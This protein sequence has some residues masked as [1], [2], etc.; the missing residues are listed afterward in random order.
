MNLANLDSFPDN[1]LNFP[2]TQHIGLQRS[3]ELTKDSKK[4]KLLKS[5]NMPS[6]PKTGPF[7]VKYYVSYEGIYHNI[8]RYFKLTLSLALQFM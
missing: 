7:A 3:G 5:L 2:N 8:W 6:M 1:A 4:G